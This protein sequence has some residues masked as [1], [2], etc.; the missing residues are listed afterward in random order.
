MWIRQVSVRN[1][2]GI[3]S[4]EVSFERGLNVLHGP[5]EIGKSTLVAAIRAALLLQHGA[6]AARQFADWH[7]DQPPRVDLTFET[8]AQRIWRVRKSFGSGSDGSSYLE[9]SRDGGT[10]TAEAKG[11]DVDGRIRELLRWGLP[12]PGGKGRTRGIPESFLSKTLLAD[13]DHVTAVL[14]SDLD[15]D[16]DESGKRRL[17][18]A[19][20]ALAEDPVFRSVLAATQER[21]EHAFTN[22]GRKSQRRTSP[23]IDLRNQ[24]RAAEQRRAEIRTRADAGEGARRRADQCRTELDEVRVRLDEARRRRARLHADWDRRQAR[25]AAREEV[26]KASRERDRIQGLHDDLE[27]AQRELSAAQR[28]LLAAGDGMAE[29]QEVETRERGRLEAARSHLAELESSDARQ[30]RTI[31]RQDLEK[32]LLANESRRTGLERRRAEA[33]RVRDLEAEAERLR[34]EVAAT[35]EKLADGR[36]LLEHTLERIREDRIEA[37]RIGERVVGL[38]ML[39]LRQQI[40]AHHRS[41]RDAERLR[42]RAQTASARASALRA[43]VAQLHLPDAEQTE[44]LR[45]LSTDLRVAEGKLQVGISVEI[46]PARPISVITSADEEPPDTVAV[47]RPTAL[48]AAA[49]LRLELDG[50]GRIDVEGGSGDAR[51]QAARLR[52]EW[53]DATAELFERLQVGTLDEVLAKCR[54]GEETIAEAERL[55]G[56]VAQAHREAAALAP[57]PAVVSELERERRRLQHKVASDLG[58]PDTEAFVRRCAAGGKTDPTV[59]EDRLDSLRRDGERR[60]AEAAALQQQ[61]AKEEGIVEAGQRELDGQEAALEASRKALADSWESVLRR[62]A[63]E[64]D[65][66]NDRDRRLGKQLAALQTEA[67]DE[68]ERSRTALRIAEERLGDAASRSAACRRAVDEARQGRDRLA[69]EVATREKLAAR[70]DLPAAQARLDELQAAFE[71]LPAPEAPVGEQ[72]RKQAEETVRS[73]TA[74]CSARQAELQQAEGA[75]QQVGGHYLQEQL[76]QADAAVEAIDRREGDVEVEYGAWKLLLETLREAEAEDAAHL[77]KALVEPVSRRVAELTDGAYGAV[78]IDPALATRSIKVAGSGRQLERFSV[79]MRDQLATVLRLTIAEKLGSTVV[80]DDQLV[81]SDPA[82]MKWL[83]GFL[84]EC[85]RKFQ[86]LVLTCHPEHYELGDGAPF[87]S[88]DLAEQ[89]ER[90]RQTTA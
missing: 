43:S 20:Q 74:A 56:E 41:A 8:E 44:R 55:A 16:A 39:K 23:W 6:T 36:S 49:R 71:T 84:I 22:T 11:R 4:V 32:R 66:L 17:T 63:T 58:E 38:Q 78:A 73:L 37:E 69:G 77:G 40:A 35:A 10:F 83:Y 12:E 2:A 61:V 51:R 9:F 47:T 88:I 59:L 75:L 28:R 42:A 64:L 80:L 60:S 62:T 46:T 48:E 86:I 85:A 14:G 19:L 65:A 89:I 53:R 52:M 29:A 33:A 7:T 81:H 5:N 15:G 76:E 90:T 1:F 70:E 3:R 54:A 87:R 82:R 24:R 26:A 31:R 25:D 68:V 72:D 27:R 21:V 67:G 79:G 57:D 45:N 18:E 13:Q 50:V 34:A 30:K